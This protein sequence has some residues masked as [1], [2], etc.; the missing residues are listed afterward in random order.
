[1]LLLI[2][3]TTVASYAI[4]LLFVNYR[5]QKLASDN[6]RYVA[7]YVAAAINTNGDDSVVTFGNV[8][9]SI[10]LTLIKADGTVTYDTTEDASAL[11]NHST[12]PEV[13][14]ARD[15]GTGSD[16]RKSD[17]V[18]MDMLYYAIRLD[19]GDILRTSESVTSV[20]RTALE[21]L[22]PMLFILLCLVIVA[23]I[24]SRYASRRIASAS[25]PRT[26]RRTP[27]RTCARSSPPMAP[28]SSRRRSPRS[29][30]MRRS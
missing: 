22:P 4:A 9:G 26:G 12:R 3:V 18:G 21:L 5:I 20:S 14:A 16:I 24:I 11:D 17:T 30:A 2:L 29:P 19:N 27:S 13:V 10:R 8:E 23:I 25:I 7:E 15:N 28:M 6:L 1:M